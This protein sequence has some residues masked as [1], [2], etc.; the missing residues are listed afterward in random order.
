MALSF[1]W[2]RPSLFPFFLAPALT[3]FKCS[4]IV[5]E[6]VP[7][8]RTLL[9]SYRVSKVQRRSGID[10]C[11]PFESP[12][13]R[14]RHPALPD[15]EARGPVYHK[16]KISHQKGV[17]VSNHFPLQV[18]VFLGVRGRFHLCLSSTVDTP[19]MHT[20]VLLFHEKWGV[21]KADDIGLSDFDSYRNS[22]IGSNQPSPFPTPEGFKLTRNGR[23]FLWPLGL[24]TLYLEAGF[25][26]AWILGAGYVT[27]VC[28][29]WMLCWG[30]DW[31]RDVGY[32]GV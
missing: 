22:L 23:V 1:S 30:G 5:Y 14:T 2:R 21:G 8:A 15:L 28:L 10:D 31:L 25:V 24:C 17:P 3:R 16:S 4:M 6:E 13:P 7:R 26:I 12:F 9:S 29:L 32:T 11:S 20:V 27:F 19:A 18:N